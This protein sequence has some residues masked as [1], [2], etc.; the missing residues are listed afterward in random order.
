MELFL[1][2]NKYYTNESVLPYLFIYTFE[3]QIQHQFFS[4]LKVAQQHFENIFNGF[5]LNP[6][7]KKDYSHFKFSKIINDGLNKC[8]K[9]DTKERMSKV[10]IYRLS[11]IEIKNGNNYVVYS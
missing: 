3:G 5:G 4:N 7:E 6:S 10:K 8:K 2:N 9:N 11:N 1:E